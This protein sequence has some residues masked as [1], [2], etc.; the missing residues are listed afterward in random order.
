MEGGL[1]EVW[2]KVI[3]LIY[4]QHTNTLVKQGIQMAL[5]SSEVYHNMQ[6]GQKAH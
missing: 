1:W 3:L 4:V 5:Q 2:S 6:Q